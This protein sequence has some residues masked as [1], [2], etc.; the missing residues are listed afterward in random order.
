MFM[1]ILQ[2]MLTWSVVIVGGVYLLLVVTTYWPGR[3]ERLQQN[4]MIPFLDDK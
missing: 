4:A 1:T 2:W 3:K